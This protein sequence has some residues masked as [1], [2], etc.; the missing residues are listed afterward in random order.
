MKDVAGRVRLIQSVDSLALAEAIGKRAPGQ[1][2]LLEVNIGAEPGKSGVLPEALDELAAAVGALGTL[3]VRGLMAIP[4]AGRPLG[5]TIGTFTKIHN[6][7]VDIRAK[8][9][10]NTDMTILSMGM[11]HD[12]EP[13]IREG[14]TMVRVGTG[15]FGQREGFM[16]T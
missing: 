8:K 7:F 4:P 6:L 16:R 10:D 9:Y 5:E 11:T 2:I 1:E 12:F 13:A 15:I 3:R 14:S